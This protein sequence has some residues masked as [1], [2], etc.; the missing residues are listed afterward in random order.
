ME[1]LDSALVIL[2]QNLKGTV[3]MITNVEKVLDVDQTIA[4]LHWD[5]IHTQI[6]VIMQLMEMRIFAEVM[7]LAMWMKVTV[8]PMMSAKAI[9][10]ADQTIVMIHLGF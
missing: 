8:I 7:I 5:L 2:V 10:F 6:A 3:T 1:K 9:F 4:Q